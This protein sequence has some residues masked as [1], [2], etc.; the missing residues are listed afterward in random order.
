MAEEGPR[1]SPICEYSW[2]E[3][4]QPAAPLLCLLPAPWESLRTFPFLS[5]SY[6]LR[7][8]HVTAH[9]PRG[10]LS[11]PLKGASNLESSQNPAVAPHFTQRNSP[12]L[13]NSSR[14]PKPVA[15]VASLTPGL[16]CPLLLTLFQ[17]YGASLLFLRLAWH[18]PAAH[19]LLDCSFCLECSS[20]KSAW[21]TPSPLFTLCLHVTFSP[22]PSPITSD[23]RGTLGCP[24]S[25]APLFP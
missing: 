19:P 11:S 24:P 6:G 13:H 8:S 7:H 20:P 4:T 3:P 17:P 21:L 9:P 2:C 15:A 18:A 1:A 12:S 22:K 14:G 23:R 25:P 10:C 5:E 16:A